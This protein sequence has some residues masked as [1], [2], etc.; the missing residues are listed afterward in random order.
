MLTMGLVSRA[1]HA[2]SHSPAQISLLWLRPSG[3][4]RNGGGCRGGCVGEGS[5][6]ESSGAKL[7]QWITNMDLRSLSVCSLLRHLRPMAQR[8]PD[9][10]AFWLQGWSE[11]GFVAA[12]EYLAPMRSQKLL[13]WQWQ[14]QILQSGSDWA[15]CGDTPAGAF[16]C[17]S[18]AVNHKFS[19]RQ[20]VSTYW[21]GDYTIVAGKQLLDSSCLSWEVVF[22]PPP[23]FFSP[24]L[25][26]F[27]PPLPPVWLWWNLWTGSETQTR[28]VLCSKTS[29]VSL[30]V[31]RVG[32][33]YC[34]WW[35]SCSS[36]QR[37]EECARRGKVE[38]CSDN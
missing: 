29:T 18:T 7:H 25:P 8:S 35:F 1:D 30:F 26:A 13:L 27:L 17:R 6:N 5:E 24:H 11:G 19:N 33:L 14:Q 38:A 36:R 4:T 16:P 23:P 3:Q 28:S 20:T 32:R 37:D 15:H 2:S 9:S 34:C 22:C 10:V 12:A 21:S 31:Q